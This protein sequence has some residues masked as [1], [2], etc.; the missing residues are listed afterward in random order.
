MIHILACNSNDFPETRMHG[1]PCIIWIPAFRAISMASGD[2][3]PGCNQTWGIPNSAAFSKT[4]VVTFGGVMTDIEV[5][6]GSGNSLKS[7]IVLIPSISDD[8]WLNKNILD[9]LERYF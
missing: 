6:F 4:P 8:F 3:D 2:S 5:V 1:P 7:Q 9:S